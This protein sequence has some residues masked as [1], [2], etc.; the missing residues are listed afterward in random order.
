MI[1]LIVSLSALVISGI[2]VY[3]AQVAPG[4]IIWWSLPL[5]FII[6]WIISF[7]LLVMFFGVCVLFQN[8]KERIIK[9][10]RFFNWFIYHMTI[11]IRI[12]YN[13]KVIVEG[14]ERIP[15]HK[16]FLIVS[17]HQSNLDPLMIISAFKGKPVTFIMKN[18]IMRVPIVGRWLYASGFL[19]LDRSNNRKAIEVI[20]ESARRLNSGFTISVYPEG[21]RSKSPRVNHFRNGIFKIV[22]KA[23][24]D[25]VVLAVDNFYK[26][27]KRFPWRRTKV[28]I[29]ICDVIP[30]DKISHLHTNEIGEMVKSI[31][32]DN[33]GDARKNYH[34]LQ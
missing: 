34:W 4:I 27:R 32:D 31:I 18:N 17:N 29:R 10:K 26:V 24:V 33:L 12:I 3:T 2:Y 8:K 19:P 25:M 20:N 13:M 23:K 11:F 22:E 9:P 16:N 21:T 14:K 5:I 7:L 15:A 30:Y 6:A 1:A 28:L